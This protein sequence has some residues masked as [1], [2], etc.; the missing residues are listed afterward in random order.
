[1]TSNQI[2]LK[3]VQI[4]QDSVQRESE[5]RSKASEVLKSRRTIEVEQIESQRQRIAKSVTQSNG[6]Y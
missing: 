6:E 3:T 1:L 5:R 4:L 2:S